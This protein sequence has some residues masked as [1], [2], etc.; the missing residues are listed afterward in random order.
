[1][2][3]YPNGYPRLAAFMS[4]EHN[5]SVYRGFDCLHSRVLLNLQDQIVEL[6]RDLDEKDQL[7]APNNESKLR[8]MSR[9]RDEREA[10]E[11]RS[12]QL[13]LNDIRTKLCEYGELPQPCWS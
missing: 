5:F 12:R 6:E 2:E 3:E 1:V 10:C 7:D 13:I 9:S 4:S 11:G 8:L